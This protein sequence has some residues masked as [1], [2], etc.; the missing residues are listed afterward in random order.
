MKTR[1]ALVLMALLPILAACQAKDGTENTATPASPATTEAPAENAPDTT[2][3]SGETAAAETAAAEAGAQADTTAPAAAPAASKPVG[4]EPVEGT[5]YVVIEQPGAFAPA[6]GKIEVA[7]VFGFVCPACNAFQPLISSW[8]A[9][10]PSDVSFVYVPAM[11]GGTWD[12]YAKAFYAAQNLGVED[13]THDA[14]Y[15]AIHVTQ[16]LKGERGR[17]SVEDIAKFYA[18][19]GVEANAFQ[20]EMK[21]FSVTNQTNKAKQFAQRTKISGTPSIIVNGKYLVKGNGFQDKLR[22]A[23][24]LIA[25]ER[26][27]KAN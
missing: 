21:S 26:A 7:E 16:D 4:P 23:D 20:K 22:I 11:F 10:L 3:A 9:G 12:D 19:H 13:K 27:A 5:D 8:K 6:T 1:F 15:A 17:D 25:R 14:L 2:A 18:K 24:H